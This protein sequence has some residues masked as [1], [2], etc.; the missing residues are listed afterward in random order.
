MAKTTNSEAVTVALTQTIPRLRE[1][2]AAL[3][4]KRSTVWFAD[5][6]LGR[7]QIQAFG[8][9]KEDALGAIVRAVRAHIE[10]TGA[11]PDYLVWAMDVEPQEMTLG[12]GYRDGRPC[13]KHAALC[14]TCADALD[15]SSA[16]T[17]ADHSCEG[18]GCTCK[19]NRKA[20]AKC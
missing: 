5:F 10:Q 11:D 4:R 9:S 8:N 6:E 17:L 13:G 3:K 12:V 7:Y 15:E 18:E 14:P 16:V 20:A 2:V 19:C 1:E